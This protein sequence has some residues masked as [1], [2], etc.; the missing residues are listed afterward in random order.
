MKCHWG[1]LVQIENKVF[2]CGF[3]GTKVTSDIGYYDKWYGS[4]IYI[5]PCGRPTFFDERDHQHPGYPYGNEVTGIEDQ[6]VKQL[7]DEARRCTSAQAYTAAV[8]ACRKLLMHIA[9]Q[10]GAP[11]GKG[12]ILYVEYLSDNHYVPPDGKQ[13][14]DEIRKKG[15]E[16]SHEILLM[17]AEDAQDILGFTEML[18]RFIYEFPYRVEQK[19][20]DS[21]KTVPKLEHYDK[22][23]GG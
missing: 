20:K 1:N 10:K 19:K 6:G 7:Y 3:C 5:C 12:F 15:N 2:V 4:F 21:K 9:V 17:I 11:P 16:A 18:L 23:P 13:W 14:V 8:L 22:G